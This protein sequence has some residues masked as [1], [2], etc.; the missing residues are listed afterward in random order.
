MLDWSY[1][2]WWFRV[3]QMMKVKLRKGKRGV[4]TQHW[5]WS[6]CAPFLRPIR[7]YHQNLGCGGRQRQQTAE[8][9]KAKQNAM[10]C[11]AR[12]QI[13]ETVALL[14]RV[15]SCIICKTPRSRFS[16][17]LCPVV[18]WCPLLYCPSPLQNPLMNRATQSVSSVYLYN[19]NILF[20]KTKQKVWIILKELSR[21]FHLIIM[22][23]SLKNM[24]VLS[25][26][27][28][29]YWYRLFAPHF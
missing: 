20:F 4:G 13:K 23:Y 16:S 29:D 3:R 5:C 28:L 11:K 7:I 9:S 8:Q 6:I 21:K 17:R 19:P 15:P 10:Q 27:S 25:A 14:P 22:R 26:S 18:G 12:L 1:Y 2:W 24:H